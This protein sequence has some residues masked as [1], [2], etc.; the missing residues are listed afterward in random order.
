MLLYGDNGQCSQS[1]N[2]MMSVYSFHF[3][4]RCWEELACKGALA[5]QLLVAECCGQSAVEKVKMIKA[6]SKP[7]RCSQAQSILN[8]SLCYP[9]QFAAAACMRSASRNPAVLVVV[10]HGARQIS[11]L[12]ILRRPP[13]VRRLPLP[14]SSMSAHDWKSSQCAA[15]R[16]M[17][18]PWKSSSLICTHFSGPRWMQRWCSPRSAPPCPGDQHI[19]VL[20]EHDGHAAGH[21]HCVHTNRTTSAQAF[22]I[23]TFICKSATRRETSLVGAMD[24][25]PQ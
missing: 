10:P 2:N 18:H 11:R 4:T 9:L 24:A 3:E 23:S 15:R 1:Q 7:V 16:A 19:D 8:L 14:E 25:L 17:N 5:N 22:G 20:L 12:L 21:P 13:V 6:R